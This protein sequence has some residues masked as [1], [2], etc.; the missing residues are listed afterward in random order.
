MGKHFQILKLDA[1]DST[2]QYL[3]DLLRSEN[4]MDY[5]VVVTERQL[6]GRGQMGTVWQSE[7]GKNLTFSVLRRFE[8]L[9]VKHQFVLNIT[10]SLAVLDTLKEL[11]IPD[12]TV[13]WPNDIMSGSKKICGILIENVLRGEYVGQS[14][15]GI[16]LNV[17]QTDFTN[18][19]KASSLKQIM[20]RNFD[21]DELL[22]GVLH[23]L[24]HHM[25]RIE[26]KTVKQLL[27]SYEKL[28]F[29]K[30]KPST[31]SDPHGNRFMGF[32]RRVSPTGKLI[33]ELEDQVLKEFD[34]KEVTLLY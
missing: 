28:L 5:T 17:N 24:Q 25:G 27:P 3:K 2:N 7:G 13:K 15:I 21:L 20:G 34:L 12:V 31:F 16:G 19:E 8:A 9:S 10:V 14:I 22:Y 29:R 33:I 11:S 1:T 18:F 6:K 32:I 30:D 26:S 4:P 23:R